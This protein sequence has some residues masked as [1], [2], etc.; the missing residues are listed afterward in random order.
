MKVL[1]AVIT[2]HRVTIWHRQLVTWLAQGCE[3][4][5]SAYAV[6][7][8]HAWY[9]TRSETIQCILV[10]KYVKITLVS[11]SVV[12]QYR[13]QSNMH[14]R[15]Q[16]VA[17]Q[18]AYLKIFFIISYDSRIS[19]K[20]YYR[21]LYCSSVFRLTIETWS[22]YTIVKRLLVAHLCVLEK[23]QLVVSQID[24]RKTR[25]FAISF[26]PSPVSLQSQGH[27]AQYVMR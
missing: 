9:H 26:N 14:L 21:S 12:V 17:N 8:R 15:F 27:W 19:S 24:S 7:L 13:Q 10:K 1:F 4:T 23:K 22:Q 18:I 3:Q 5:F 20:C 6:L 25:F 2:L 16:Y 11:S